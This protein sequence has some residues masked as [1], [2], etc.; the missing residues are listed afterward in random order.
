MLDEKKLPGVHLWAEQG[1]TFYKDYA[2]GKIPRFILLSSDG[3]IIS[4]DAPRP[5]SKEIRELIDSNL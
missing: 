2:I 1:N 5:G 4:P 3:K